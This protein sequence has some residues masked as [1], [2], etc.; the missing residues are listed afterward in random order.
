MQYIYVTQE[1]SDKRISIESD[2]ADAINFITRKYQYMLEEV[3]ALVEEINYMVAN[4]M[5][6][7]HA[8]GKNCYQVANWLA[9]F[10][11]MDMWSLVWTN[12]WLYE[13]A[14]L[15]FCDAVG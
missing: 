1:G 13:L 4:N 5:F 8:V 11:R 14:R 6:E 10:A 9:I 7:F 2:Y 3:R 15:L 12:N